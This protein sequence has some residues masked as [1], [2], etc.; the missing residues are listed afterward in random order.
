MKQLD[1]SQLNGWPASVSTFKFIQEQ[2]LQ[3][4]MLSLLGGNTYILQGCQDA[5]GITGDGWVVIAGEVL[6]FVG[7]ATQTNVVVVE[8]VVDRSFFE[9]IGILPYYR[10]RA[11]TFG[12]AATQYT[13]ADFERNDPGNGLVKRM[14]LAEALLVCL[15]TALATTNSNLSNKA[16]KSNVLQLNNTTSYT[17]SAQ[18]HPATKEYVDTTQGFKLAFVGYLTWSTLIVTAEKASALTISA[19]RQS[20]GRYRIVHS[21]GNANYF[22]TSMGKGSGDCVGPK[23]ITKSTNYF[24]IAVSD[25]GSANDKDIYFQIFT[26]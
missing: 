19:A 7:G 11:A 3:L 23:T 6:P 14:R 13:W 12:T 16:D 5:A 20:E 9:N 18:Y 2:M 25:D 17:P 4:Q 8:T 24:D 22:V 26:Y 21:L 15:Q 10:N 1:F